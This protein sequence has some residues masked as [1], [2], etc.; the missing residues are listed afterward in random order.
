[1]THRRRTAKEKELQD[2]TRLL[3]AWHRFHAEELETAMNGTH[4]SIIARLM[5]ILRALELGSG[6]A[7][8][9]F[10]E[11]RNWHVVDAHTKLV[12]LHQLNRAVTKLRERNGQPPIDDGLGGERA[13]VFR[14]IRSI[15]EEKL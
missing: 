12:V 1:M 4:G 6:P 11:A 7:L 9:D 2:N 14:T 3:R 5:E 15:F 8:I 13:N 10:V